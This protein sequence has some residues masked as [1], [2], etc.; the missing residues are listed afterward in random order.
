M[1]S[2]IGGL[3][4]PDD[5]VTPVNR[6]VVLVAGHRDGDIDL[7]GPALLRPGLGELHCPTD[8]L[9]LPYRLGWSVR[10]NLMGASVI[11]DRCLFIIRA[12]MRSP[13]WRRQSGRPWANSS[14]RSN[15]SKA[16][17]SAMA[18]IGVARKSHSVFS[19]RMRVPE[20]KPQNRIHESRSRTMQGVCARLNPCSDR[21]TGI[22]KFNTGS[23]GRRLPFEGAL[24]RSAFIKTDHNISKLTVAASFSSRSPYADNSFSRSSKSHNPPCPCITSGKSHRK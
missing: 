3:F 14:A 1:G 18:L 20:P 6:D 2:R 11:L 17:S 5:A 23:N 7:R 8:R 16:L 15:R 21:S 10:P 12:S 19:S 13:T 22:L 4:A 9:V 24:R